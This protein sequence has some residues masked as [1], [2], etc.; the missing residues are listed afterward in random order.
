MNRSKDLLKLRLR[1]IAY[2]RSLPL[3]VGDRVCLRLA[4]KTDI[5]EIIR[6]Q[7]TS[8]ES[9]L[10]NQFLFSRL[11]FGQRKLK[12]RKQNFRAIVLAIYLFSII[13]LTQQ[14]Y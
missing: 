14:Q 9:L 8:I 2:G 12:F 7:N 11:N 5:P 13:A 4:T 3:L 6:I 1:S 10:P